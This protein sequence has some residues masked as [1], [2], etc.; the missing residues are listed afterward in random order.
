MFTEEIPD[1]PIPCFPMAGGWLITKEFC[2]YGGGF[3][4]LLQ[5]WERGMM[6]QFDELK[7]KNPRK[8][9]QEVAEE[10][11]TYEGFRMPFVNF[12]SCMNDVTY[13]CHAV[14]DEDMPRCSIGLTPDS[15]GR[16]VPTVE[17][18]YLGLWMEE[19]EEPSQGRPPTGMVIDRDDPFSKVDK[20]GMTQTESASFP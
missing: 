17:F 8:T 20:T 10:F 5:E 11:N 18:N 1:I 3:E 12:V 9:L 4:E 14:K 2:F 16:K 19:A 6:Y 15:R 13:R 7:K